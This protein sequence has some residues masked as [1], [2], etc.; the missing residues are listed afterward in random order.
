MPQKPIILGTTP[1]TAEIAPVQKINHWI[2]RSKG[3][4]EI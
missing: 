3:L 2:K 1:E 4:S